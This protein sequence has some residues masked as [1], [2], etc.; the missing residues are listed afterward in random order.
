MEAA[1]N[2]LRA[3]SKRVSALTAYSLWPIPEKKILESLQGIKRI[4]IPEMNHG[5]YRHEI[6][7]LT[8]GTIELVGVNRVDTFLITPEDITDAYYG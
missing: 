4:I 7:R 8:N 5:Q 2:Q 3:K 6:E 1:V